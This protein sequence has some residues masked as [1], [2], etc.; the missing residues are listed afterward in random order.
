[1]TT[2]DVA[3]SRR[4]AASAAM[5][6]GA[7]DTRLSAIS[8]AGFGGVEL[9]SSDVFEGFRGAESNLDLIASSGLS[10]PLFQM[11]RNFE[12]SA[13][14]ELSDSIARHC[15]EHA[16]WVGADTVVL[17]AN[18]RE[19]SNG[20]RTEALA[21][22]D[23]LGTLAAHHGCRVAYEPLAWARWMSD[24]RDAGALIA[25]LDHPHVGLMLD[26]SHIAARGLD[27]EH[28]ADLDPA[29]I[30]CVEIADLPI[31]SLPS[32]D[33]SRDYRLL[34]GEGTVKLERFVEL[35]ETGGYRGAYSL[36]VF[37][38]RV[39]ELP[40]KEAAASAYAALDALWNNAT[41][42]SR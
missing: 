41:R 39:R 9:F 10:V 31:T 30:F 19:D 21:D 24:Y 28:V 14:G 37:S 5:F 17:C 18:T 25:E 23:R 3:P 20:D 40:A 6:S 15:F 2:N 4:F 33:V 35:L 34:P 12:G 11:L 42:S 27:F 16:R 26:S 29:S 32:I 36:E 13:E 7:L 1:M 8:D 22:L 38:A